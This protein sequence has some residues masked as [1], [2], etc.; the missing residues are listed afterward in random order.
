[1]LV[2]LCAPPAPAD[3]SICPRKAPSIQALYLAICTQ[4][5]EEPKS[6]AR[7]WQAGTE[8]LGLM[9]TL[10]GGKEPAP[11]QDC[12]AAVQIESQGG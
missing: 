5:R 11:Q 6:R 9:R 3:D 12:P 2:Q 10:A 1:M 7:L 8:A 4:G